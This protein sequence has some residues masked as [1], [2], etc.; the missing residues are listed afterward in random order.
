M[1][2]VLQH[3]Y[4]PAKLAVTVTS[5]IISPTKAGA[6]STP[7]RV[8]KA[9]RGI[10]GGVCVPQTLVNACKN[11]TGAVSTPHWLVDIAGTN[12]ASP[13]TYSCKSLR[14][15][16]EVLKIQQ[17]EKVCEGWLMFGR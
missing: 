17:P 15:L 5:A 16:L 1:A 6:V 11:Y 12:P 4:C 8:I 10:V 3:S 14:R 2:K 13:I 7:Q 9:R